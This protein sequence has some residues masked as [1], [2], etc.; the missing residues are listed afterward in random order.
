MKYI[1]CET[2]GPVKVS[3]EILGPREDEKEVD[4]LEIITKAAL[5]CRT[6]FCT[7]G[8]GVF[9]EAPFRILVCHY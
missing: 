6:F 1:R 2:Y 8:A 7:R 5:P 3:E 9:P 4:Q